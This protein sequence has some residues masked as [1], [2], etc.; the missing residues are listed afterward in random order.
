MIGMFAGAIGGV[1]AGLAG[2]Q[3][4]GVAIGVALKCLGSA[5]AAY[6][7]LAMLADVIDIL[8]SRKTSAPTA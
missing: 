4:I 7:I 3:I 1:I 2:G 8:S 6:M 5:P